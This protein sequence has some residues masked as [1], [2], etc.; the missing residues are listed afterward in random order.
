MYNVTVIFEKL[1]CLDTESIHS[2]DKFALSGGLKSD[3]G[4]PVGFYLPTIRI[5]TNETREIDHEF[6]LRADQPEVHLALSAWDLDEGDS[7]IESKDGIKAAS[8]FISTAL[9]AVPGW[10]AAAG[11]AV[12]I[13]STVVIEAVNL[14]NAWDKDD[15]LLQT[16][17]TIDI[18]AAAPYEVGYFRKQIKFSGSD[19]VG[20]SSW[21]YEL[22]VGIRY[23]WMPQIAPPT[24]IGPGEAA[25]QLF[26]GRFDTAK[27]KRFAA[28]FPTFHQYQHGL[29]IVTKTAYLTGVV[30]EWRDVPLSDLGS[31]A[32][33]DFARR[34]RETAQYAERNGF[35][36]GFPNFYHEDYGSGI[37]CGTILLRAPGAEW[38]DVRLKDLGNP[39]LN[40][41]EERFRS[42]HDYAV[43]NGYASGFPNFFHAEKHTI[44]PATGQRLRFT[45]CGIILIKHHLLDGGTGRRTLV[46]KVI[47]E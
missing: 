29:S 44:D 40:N 5:N 2:S 25:A 15:R 33:D 39:D 27:G 23:E 22:E 24:F 18:P 36:G 26:R 16:D 47:E 10:G 30:A 41:P 43:A 45:V 4:D 11:T 35:V 37:V 21:K 17:M 7:W 14:F 8:E 1:T 12:K 38:Q 31:V 20:H 9:K 34:M 13:A 42:A 3:V 32:L 28:A 46:C 19:P 6:S